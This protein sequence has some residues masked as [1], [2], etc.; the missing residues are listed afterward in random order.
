MDLGGA[1]TQITFETASPSEDPENEIHLQLYGQHYRV[2]THSFLCYGRDQVLQ[3]LLASALQVCLQTQPQNHTGAFWRKGGREKGQ[4]AT[5]HSQ[6]AT[7]TDL[8]DLKRGLL[9]PVTIHIPV[10]PTV[11]SCLPVFFS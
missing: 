6:K 8:G 3:R 2:Y 5:E 10:R 4:K 9:F 1:S 11:G 7:H